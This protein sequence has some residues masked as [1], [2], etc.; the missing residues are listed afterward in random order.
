MQYTC[1]NLVWLR[2]CEHVRS[3]SASE[4]SFKRIPPVGMVG[5]FRYGIGFYLCGPL[6][7]HSRFGGG[8]T[9]DRHY[10]LGEPRLSS[11]DACHCGSPCRDF[12]VS[13]LSKT[14][15]PLVGRARYPG[16]LSTFLWFACRV[17]ERMRGARAFGFR[18]SIGNGI[19]VDDFG[20]FAARLRSSSQL[21]PLPLFGLLPFF[22]R[23][24]FLPRAP[25]A[26]IPFIS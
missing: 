15:R 3:C 8:F 2:G 11:L 23:L 9:H 25:N 20:W 7:A 13:R 19:F 10:F 17:V 21:S 1:K 5:P 22:L 14:S 4:L 26:L 6:S 18:F 24:S 12:H 16:N